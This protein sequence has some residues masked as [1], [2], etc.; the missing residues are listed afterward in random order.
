MAVDEGFLCGTRAMGAWGMA[1]RG[2]SDL[3]AN[4]S[5]NKSFEVSKGQKKRCFSAIPEERTNNIVLKQIEDRDH[6]LTECLS[7]AL[8]RVFSAGRGPWAPGGWRGGVVQ[9]CL[10]I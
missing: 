1:W 4:I 10:P 6:R 2:R 7:M 5:V 8:M 3:F 9:I